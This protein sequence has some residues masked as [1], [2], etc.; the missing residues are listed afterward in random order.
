[1]ENKEQ[2]Q[3]IQ[4]FETLLDRADKANEILA[5]A[6]EA[7]EKAAPLCAELDEYLSGEDWKQDFEDDEA[8]RL[9]AELKRGVLSEDGIFNVLEERRQLMAEMLELVAR[10]L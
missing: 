4:R 7:F 8:G 1:M 9:P 3:R 5:R 6:L 10:S 2:L